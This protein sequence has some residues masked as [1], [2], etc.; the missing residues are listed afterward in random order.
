M[1]E[2]DAILSELEAERGRGATRDALLERAVALIER[3]GGSYDWVGIY[4]LEGETLVLHS[5]VG[6]P[7]DHTHI[8]IGQGVCGTAIAEDRDLNIA[9]VH[10]IDNYLACSLETASELVVLIREPESGRAIGQLDLDSDRRGAFGPHDERELRRVADWLGAL[11][12]PRR[13][14]RSGASSR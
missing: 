6:K 1:I 14:A 10:A 5:Y 8:A 7:T 12:R 9:D 3:A 13:T 4:L 2:A 11:F